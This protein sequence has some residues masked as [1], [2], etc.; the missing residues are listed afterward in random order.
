MFQVRKSRFCGIS[1]T[2]FQCC[3]MSETQVLTSVSNL[4][5]YLFIYLFGG[6]VLVIIFWKEEDLSGRRIYFLMGGASFL[7]GGG[8]GVGGGGAPWRSISFDGGIFKKNHGMGEC[9]SCLPTMGNPVSYQIYT[10]YA[11]HKL[12]K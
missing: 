8:V 2:Y 7:S 11:I 12:Q 10:Y 4:F 1:V 5:I 3:L 9:P 6:G